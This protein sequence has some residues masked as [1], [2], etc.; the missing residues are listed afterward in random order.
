M[1][2]NKDDDEVLNLAEIRKDDSNL[3]VAA[4]GWDEDTKDPAIELLKQ[5]R[6]GTE[7]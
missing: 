6:E 2:K 1:G 5:L 4:K 7:D 3:N